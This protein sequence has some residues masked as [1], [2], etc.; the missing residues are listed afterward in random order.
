MRDVLEVDAH[1]F[2]VAHAAV[3]EGGRERGGE[4]VGL[5][6]GE[7]G[8]EV[9]EGGASGSWRTRSCQAATRVVDRS[10]LLGA[11]ILPAGSP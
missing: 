7:C 6:D 1:P 8:V 9:D 5:A 11:D 4:V 2:T 3:G 10:G